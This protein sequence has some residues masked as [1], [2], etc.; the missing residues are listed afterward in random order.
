[1]LDLLTP[2]RDAMFAALQSRVDAS[3]GAVL[4]PVPENTLP[5][6]FTFGDFESEDASD[7]GDQVE[8]I[9]G[10]VV[11]LYRGD[12]SRVF[13]AMIHAARAALDRQ[14]IAGE[15]VA[16]QAPRWLKTEAGDGANDDRLY[17]AILTFFLWAE[18]A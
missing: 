5:P 9:T 7:K 2:V 8:Q 13:Y 6:F 18:P 10:R 17:A 12:D 16:L 14:P 4:D 1:M 11:V 3:L 15:G